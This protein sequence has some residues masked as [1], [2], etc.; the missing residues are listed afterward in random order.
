MPT[1]GSKLLV[2]DL[3]NATSYTPTWTAGTT[4]P[5]L[6]AST[7]DGL[8]VRTGGMV[9]VWVKV[10]VGTGFAAG[11]GFYKFGLPIFATGGFFQG[12]AYL[13]RSGAEYIGI[14]RLADST[15][16]ALNINKQNGTTTSGTPI[17][18]DLVSHAFPATPAV[19]DTY[20]F[21]I[22]YPIA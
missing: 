21:T 16:V 15:N 9:T 18:T 10:T 12:S 19:G 3:T 8:Y 5:T 22:S 7:R 6:G 20:Q 13:T 17:V 14:C 11:S 1:A 2:T 4:N